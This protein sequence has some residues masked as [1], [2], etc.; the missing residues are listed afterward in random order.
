MYHILTHRQQSPTNYNF[1]TTHHNFFKVCHI[2]NFTNTYFRITSTVE[3]WK[4]KKN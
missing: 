4:V 3:H 1:K 2:N